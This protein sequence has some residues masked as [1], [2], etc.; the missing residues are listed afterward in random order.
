M[1]IIINDNYVD[2]RGFSATE[3]YASFSGFIKVRKALV[4]G[5]K[6]ITAE[7]ASGNANAYSKEVKTVDSSGNDV[8]DASGNTTHT[9]V[10]YEKTNT[11]KYYV[12]TTLYQYK[13]KNSRLNSMYPINTYPVRIYVELSEFGKIFELLYNKIKNDKSLYP[14]TSTVDDL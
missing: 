3:T 14:F 1:G 6:T 13:D 9:V 7:D 11:W 4:D 8:L 12:E 5:S 2:P 10:Y